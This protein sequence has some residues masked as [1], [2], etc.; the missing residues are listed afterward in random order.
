MSQ[1]F[2]TVISP[3]STAPATPGRIKAAR[4]WYSCLTWALARGALAQRLPMPPDVLL[5]ML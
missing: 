5:A 1:A 2:S 4:H 3:L